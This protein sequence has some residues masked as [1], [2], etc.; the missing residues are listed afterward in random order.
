MRPL[1]L[2][3]ATVALLTGCIHAPPKAIEKGDVPQ[4]WTGA[5]VAQGSAW[6]TRDWWKGFG[7]KELESLLYEAEANSFDTRAAALR[8]VQAEAQ[9]TSAGSSLWPTL[10]A[11]AGETQSGEF[12]P[13]TSSKRFTGSLGLNYELD[14]WGQNLAGRRSAVASLAATRFDQAAVGLAT[15]S[16]VATAYVEVLSLRDQIKVAQ[17]DLDI[18][19]QTLKLIQS[20][21]TNGAAP[22]S[23][24]INQQ[25]A[26]ARQAASIPP[27]VQQERS[28]L[29]SLAILLGRPSSG[30]D[31]QGQ[32]LD[33]LVIPGVTPGLPSQLLARRP[34]VAEAEAQLRS[35]SADLAAARAAFFP[36]I[37][38]TGSAGNVS[39]ALSALFNAGTATWTAGGT[40]AE[41]IF[42]AGRRG[43]AAKSAKAQESVL[44]LAYRKAVLSAFSEVDVTLS[45]VDTLAQERKQVDIEVASAREAYRLAQIQYREGA[46]DLTTVL[47]AQS[48]LFSAESQ[49][50]QVKLQ[51]AEAA[52]ELYRALG[53]GWDRSQVKI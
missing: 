29:A 7:S 2:G 45:S 37:D 9:V 44:V 36:S 21:V 19:N 43:A 53:G 11:Q 8:V 47:Q 1:L 41:T 20:R 25:A 50:T 42:D 46:T 52:I 18:A 16:G 14:I 40:I 27:L 38:L 31:I 33:A 23:D 5:E 12:R 34:D 32:S 22:P 51:Q 49:L 48:T 39:T 10:S 35:A 28:T 3:A 6:P 24:L 26:V 13:N 30:F 4:K 15:A 17:A